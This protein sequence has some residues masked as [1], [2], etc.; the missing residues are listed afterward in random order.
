MV[1]RCMFCM[2]FLV[3]GMS[4]YRFLRSSVLFVCMAPLTSVAITLGGLTFQPCA[5]IFSIS[6]LHLSFFQFGWLGWCICCVC[7]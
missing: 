3:D 6:G 2:D 1:T 4:M 5:R 7:K